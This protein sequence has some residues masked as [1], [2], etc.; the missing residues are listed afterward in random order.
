MSKEKMVKCKVCGEDIAKNAK[1]CPKCGA[2]NK[3]PFAKII[4][5]GVIIV[6]VFFVLVGCLAESNEVD[7]ENI[8]YVSVT[9]TELADALDKNAASANDKYTN[10][11]L[12][13][14]GRLSNI[15]S[16]CSYIDIVDQNDEWS[17]LGVQCYTN[18]DDDII[19]KIKKLNVGDIITVSGK[20]TDVGEVLGYSLD[21]YSI[22]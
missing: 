6:V 5:I 16:D 15:D 21:I 12:S 13:I 22:E 9:A 3:S 19:S 4:A 17:I 7:K 14:T 10:Q 11:Y 18:G 2:K 20:I 8:E 1:I